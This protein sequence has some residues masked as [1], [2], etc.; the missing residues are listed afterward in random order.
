MPNCLYCD[1]ELPG[2]EKVC[3]SCY[4]DQYSKLNGPVQPIS[5]RLRRLLSNPMGITKEK[6]ATTPNP[7]F[8]VVIAC[9]VAGLL[10]CWLG[11]FARIHY[12]SSLLSELAIMGGI[13]CLILSSSYVLLVAR[14]GL[15]ILWKVVPYA[16]LLS[17]WGVAGWYFI[18]ASAR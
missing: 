6:L 4:D 13:R 2:T 5:V 9:G 17:S 11:G 1:C 10:I 8:V 7:S 15:N 3:R 18:G 16:F 14:D 12:R